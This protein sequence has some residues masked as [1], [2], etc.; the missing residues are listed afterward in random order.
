MEVEPGMV[1]KKN[2]EIP[3]G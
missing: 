2:L 1:I 3:T